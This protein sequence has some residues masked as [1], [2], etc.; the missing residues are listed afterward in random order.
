MPLEEKE[1]LELKKET[2]KLLDKFSLALSKIKSEKEWNVERKED[3]R[4]EGGGEGCDK[5]FRKIML[6]NAPQHDEDFIIAEKK[7]W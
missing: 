3:R 2:K 6:N 4:K 7:S 1:V 5:D